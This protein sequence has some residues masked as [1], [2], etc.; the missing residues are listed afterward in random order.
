MYESKDNNYIFKKVIDKISHIIETVKKKINEFFTS[1]KLKDMEDK[2]N[3]I[4]KNNPSI[5]NQKI[6]IRDIKKLD[7]LNRKTADELLKSKNP[8]EVFKKYKKQ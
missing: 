7:A 6:K 3:E 2:T 1:K 4:L 8:E 5:K